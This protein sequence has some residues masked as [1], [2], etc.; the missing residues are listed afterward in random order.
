MPELRIRRAGHGPR[1]VFVHASATDHTTWSIQL[2]SPL[3]TRFELVAY[4]RR[5]TATV[6]D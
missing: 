3:R 5:V 2:E 6:E 1:V 4:D